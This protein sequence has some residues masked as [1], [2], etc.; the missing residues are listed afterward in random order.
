[1]EKQGR[2]LD[3]ADFGIAEAA[4]GSCACGHVSVA[5]G[6]HY[7]LGPY[8]AY[9]LTAQHVDAGDGVSVHDGVDQ[10]GMEQHFDVGLRTHSV[11]DVL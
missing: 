11:K 9:A 10:G 2:R 5:S 7:N 4:W 1:M 6:V 3:G 8:A